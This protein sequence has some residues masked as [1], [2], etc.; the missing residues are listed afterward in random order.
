MKLVG[1]ISDPILE[2]DSST[3]L[4]T[5]PI[6]GL[7]NWDPNK[8]PDLEIISAYAICK[9]Q[10][11]ASL[12]KFWGHLQNGYEEDVYVPYPGFRNVFGIPI[13]DITNIVNPD[14]KRGEI[15]TR[16]AASIR[17]IESDA[18]LIFIV[19]PYD[20]PQD[21]L[22][23]YNELKATSFSRRI[24]T[25]CIRRTTLERLDET[26]PTRSNHAIDLWNISVGIFAKV[27]GTPWGLKDE[28]S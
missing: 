25:Q 27:G 10:L 13:A 6:F 18:D 14:T 19:L 9:P 1:Y 23:V 22:E 4:S 8:I 7:E 11:Q 20:L 15:S 2:F 3:H 28:M 21:A 26:K 24:K 5:D 16:Y 12:A 17:D